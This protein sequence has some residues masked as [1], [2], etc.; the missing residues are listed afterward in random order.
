MDPTSGRTKSR[1]SDPR[2]A[3]DPKQDPGRLGWGGIWADL[4][5]V[6]PG[7]DSRPLL[8]I[9]SSQDGEKCFRTKEQKPSW[10][11][12]FSAVQNA[13]CTNILVNLKDKGPDPKFHAR[14]LLTL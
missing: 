12:D 1:L 11:Q 3:F 13:N 7:N 4:L 6:S 10:F 9:P 2:L 14:L 5:L 8:M